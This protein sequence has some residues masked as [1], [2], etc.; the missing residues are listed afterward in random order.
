MIICEI[1]TPILRRK[2]S[3]WWVVGD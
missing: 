2:N 1:N 3:A